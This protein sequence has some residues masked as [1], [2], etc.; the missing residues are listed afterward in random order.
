MAVDLTALNTEL[1]SDPTALGYASH[2]A[3]GADGTLAELLNRTRPTISV[4][5]ATI[6]TW[7][8]IAATES[9]DWTALSVE[10][11]DRYRVIVSAGVIDVSDANIRALLGALLP[12]GSATRANLIAR[13][14]RPGSRAEQLFGVSVSSD[15]IAKALRG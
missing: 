1:T 4:K 12:A 7:E 6:Q 5:R 3:A 10:A 2:V 15:E 8:I 13:I 9:A 11:K 14:S